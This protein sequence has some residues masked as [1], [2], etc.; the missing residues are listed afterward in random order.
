MKHTSTTRIAGAAIIGLALITAAGCS[1]DS[2]A[3]ST[4]STTIASGALTAVAPYSGATIVVEGHG[5]ATGTPDTM[6]MTIGVRTSAGSAA[7]A[8]DRNNVEATALETTLSAKGVDD[9]DMQTSDLSISPDYDQHGRITGYTAANTVTLT[10]HGL[11]AGGRHAGS[12]ID[13]GAAAVGN[14]ITFDGVEL[15]IG[16]TSSL[17][18]EA[19]ETRSGRPSVTRS[20]SSRRPA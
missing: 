2:S 11:G 9:K 4:T 18:R 10:L 12:V 14:D 7:A 19:R 15:S 16:D 5:E 20:S 17:L 8:L 3:A 6:T 1:T 13:A